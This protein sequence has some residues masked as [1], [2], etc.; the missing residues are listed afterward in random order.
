METVV[1]PPDLQIDRLNRLSHDRKM[2]RAQL[3]RDAVSQY[4]KQCIDTQAR[5]YLNPHETR[6]TLS[7]SFRVISLTPAIA[8]RAANPRRTSKLKLPD[9]VILATAQDE[10]RR[11]TTRNTRGLQAHPLPT[12][13]NVYSHA[14]TRPDPPACG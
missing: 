5:D 9:A 11:L 1:D 8:E 13:N 12:L 2:P 4:L 6:K 10:D 14:P 3:V 7:Q